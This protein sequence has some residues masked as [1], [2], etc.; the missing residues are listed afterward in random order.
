MHNMSV[1]ESDLEVTRDRVEDLED[2]DLEFM[3][4]E[5]CKL[6][7]EL[8]EKIHKK[9]KRVQ[10]MK[11]E[12]HLMEQIH[13]YSEAQIMEHIR[14]LEET[15]EAKNAEIAAVTKRLESEK[16][17]HA[18]EIERQQKETED[19]KKKLQC[20]NE[21]EE[22]M[23]LIEYENMQENKVKNL[24]EKSEYESML[25]K[26]K[27]ENENLNENISKLQSENND[28]KSQLNLRSLELETAHLEL[29]EKEEELKAKQ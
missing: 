19:V 20:A 7:E 24:Q 3:L 22:M 16:R 18:I 11:K 9:E 12:K 4:T 28:I 10:T 8:P 29:K 14:K 1:V 6:V 2:L 17:N 5:K 23:E 25:K 27:E 15:L 13:K 26:S 21:E